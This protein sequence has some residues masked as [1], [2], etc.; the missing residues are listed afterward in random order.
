MPNSASPSSSAAAAA[1][2]DVE[3]VERLIDAPAATIFALLADPARHH[4]FDGSGTVKGLKAP[5]GQ[6]TLG[7]TFEMKM[8]MGIPYTMVNTIIEFEQDRLIAWQPRP[9][10]KLLALGVG[11]RIW[12]YELEPQAAGTLVKE[13]WDIHAEKVTALV[14][15]LRAKT[16]AAMTATLERLERVVAS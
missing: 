1:P 2:G 10:N 15:P 8:K 5:A 12:R 9:A 13:S 11:G 6:M 14:K 16:V 7:S 4:E 3:T